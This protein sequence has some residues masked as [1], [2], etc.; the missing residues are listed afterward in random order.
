MEMSHNVGHVLKYV[1]CEQTLRSD[2][3]WYFCKTSQFYFSVTFSA[4]YF[5]DLVLLVQRGWDDWAL[6]YTVLLSKN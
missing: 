4:G 3:G 1:T 2:V 5:F 6:V